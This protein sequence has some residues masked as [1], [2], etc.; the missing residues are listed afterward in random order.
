MVSGLLVADGLHVFEVDPFQE[1][2]FFGLVVFDQM[3]I[4][5]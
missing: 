1:G 5:D 3:R 4:L 2:F